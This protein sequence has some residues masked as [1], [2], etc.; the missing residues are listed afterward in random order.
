MTR[1]RADSKG[2][3][4]KRSPPE[5][6]TPQATPPPENKPGQK[7]AAPIPL[8]TRIAGD[9]ALSLEH[10]EWV[11]PNSLGG[12]AM[13]TALGLPTRRY[14]ALLVTDSP[15]STQRRA[16][17]AHIAERLVIKSADGRD[18]SLD[19]ST[20]RFASPDPA[21]V[22]HPA[23]HTHLVR[24]EKDVAC[25]WIFH[26][27]PVELT[28]ELILP[29]GTRAGMIRYQIK[30]R[31]GA[32]ADVRLELLPMVAMRDYHA[33]RHALGDAPPFHVESSEIAGSPRVR[34]VDGEWSLL[35]AA[36]RGQTRHPGGCG[37][38]RQFFYRVERDRGQDHT[39]DLYCPA[40]FVADLAARKQADALV[41]RFG[42]DEREVASLDSFDAE[43]DRLRARA[44]DIISASLDRCAG[45][46]ETD[47][48]PLA[49]LALA[50][51]DFVIHPRS[52]LVPADQRGTQPTSIIAGY[53][54]FTD[55][56]RDTMI[57]LPGLLLE[58]GRF[59]E[60]LAALR[61][62]AA[63]RRHGIIPNRF[64]DAGHAGFDDVEYNTIDASL[65]FII[66]SHRFLDASGDRTAFEQHLL[67]ACL[68][69]IESYRKGTDHGI[70][71]D[72]ADHLIAGGS[73]TT[74]LTWMDA[75]RDGICFTPRHG[76][77]VEINALWHSSLRLLAESLA[78]RP[79]HSALAG[80]LRALADV[81]AR[82]FR[83][84]FFSPALG[85]CY[86][87]ISPDASGR[88]QPVGEIRP[89]Q[90]FAISLPHSPL[91]RDEQLGVLRVVRERLLT[92][93]GLRTLAPGSRGYAPRFR[94][95]LFELDAA[96]HNGTVWPWLLGPYAEAVAR[97]GEFSPESIREARQALAPII[98][99]L[100]AEC[101]G[102]IAE[103]FDAEGTPGDPQ[104]AGGC[105]AQ[106]WSVA[107]TRRVLA[108]LARHADR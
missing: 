98:R 41:I 69:V 38:W 74:Q 87:A 15:T 3:G 18:E 14:H 6:R 22:I 108:L 49:A 86:D 89:N 47:A 9:H 97:A 55:W 21:G 1:K 19:L 16:T 103:V 33:V 37:W 57:S 2:R 31:R 51:D 71:M 45:M 30:A 90:V 34:A 52:S 63:A 65:W 39:E 58:S 101:V 60:A 102:S 10:T 25:R 8:Y 105:P 23:G 78:S 82:S 79:G 62:F 91:L 76:K 46:Q 26:V 88:W 7:H 28:K 48:G 99:K 54:W 95:P 53:P 4:S 50:A 40:A 5:T 67:P 83:S 72:P 85:F 100:D 93:F 73:A 68:D 43:L 64:T 36:D 96:Y 70:G 32:V 56:G 107:E 77:A 75:R 106:A 11:L 94:G 13:G 29:R 20:F 42:V 80:D 24:F 59:S 84:A 61:R 17:L 27:G 104:R 92:P 12:F 66:A 81:V 44:D 35:I